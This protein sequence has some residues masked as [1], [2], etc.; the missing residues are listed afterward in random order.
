[1]VAKIGIL[2]NNVK[3]IFIF[4]YFYILLTVLNF[5]FSYWVGLKLHLFAI[6]ICNSMIMN[7]MDHIFICLL[8]ICVP[9]SRKFVL[10][11]LKLDYWFF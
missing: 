6:L 1:M 4:L 11:I 2:T 10:P 7:D 5:F 8:A 9:S 3:Q